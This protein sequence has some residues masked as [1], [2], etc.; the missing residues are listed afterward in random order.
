MAQ[1]STRALADLLGCFSAGSAA[2]G[3]AAAL[4]G[5]L[6]ASVLSGVTRTEAMAGTGQA[7]FDDA[8]TA[9][10]LL[11]EYLLALAEQDHAAQERLSAAYP[12]PAR[13]PD[14][15]ASRR[16]AVRAAMTAATD[17]RLRIMSVC[18]QVLS[19]AV[20]IA[21][22]APVRARAEV[23][24][25]V[26]LLRASFEGAGIC[27]AASLPAIADADYVARVTDHQRQLE[28]DVVDALAAIRLPLADT[29][30]GPVPGSCR[31]GI[32]Y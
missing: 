7:Q 2:A 14:E 21:T 23:A 27:V 32:V 22:Y 12:L 16:A 31:L 5:A 29:A 24:V 3:A 13:T 30:P 28:S 15:R 26:Q 4:S 1:F 20:S 8:V 6:G 11:S 19:A 17:V 10:R 25:G 9:I 18:E